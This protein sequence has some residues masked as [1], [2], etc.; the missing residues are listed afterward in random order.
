MYQSKQARIRR[1]TT[2][3]NSGFAVCQSTRQRPKNTRQR[4]C[5]VLHTVNSARQSSAGIQGVC[6]VPF[7]GHT[8]K[9]LPCVLSGPRQNKVT[10]S[11]SMPRG[12]CLRACWASVFAVRQDPGHT[13]K[14]LFAVCQ[15]P[16]HTPNS[17]FAVCPGP[18]HTANN[19]LQ[20]FFG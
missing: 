16:M 8:A 18:R 3:G 11:P 15:D 12:L 2:T 5:R 1:K 6:R 14:A 4:I 19:F 20:I 17:A 10:P 9:P 7:F 13:A